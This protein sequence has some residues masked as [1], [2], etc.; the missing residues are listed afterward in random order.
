MYTDATNG[1]LVEAVNTLYRT[2]AYVTVAAV[3]APRPGSGI[4]SSAEK[5]YVFV[6]SEY[7]YVLPGVVA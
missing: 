6:T 7:T 3:G 5:P 1:A 2:G 4:T